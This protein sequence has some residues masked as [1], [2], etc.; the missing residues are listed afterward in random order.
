MDYN[1]MVENALRGVVREALKEV[2][3]NGLHG[4]HHFYISFQTGAEGVDIPD[5]LRARY[6]GEMTI[7]LQHQFWNLEVGEEAFSVSLSFNKIQEDLHIPYA[8]I[9]AFADPSV[10]FGLQFQVA[11]TDGDEEE[12]ASESG[13]DTEDSAGTEDGQ[14]SAPTAEEGGDKGG[15]VITLDAF[16]KKK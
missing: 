9:T 3:E 2:A 13:E 11:D 16:R 15:D 12:A 5:H 8:A 4:N 14:H 7:I 6:P 1:S 10:Q